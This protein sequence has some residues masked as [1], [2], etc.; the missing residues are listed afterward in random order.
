M[1]KVWIK[2]KLKAHLCLSPLV[3][4][5]LLVEVARPCIVGQDERVVQEKAR[6][7]AVARGCGCT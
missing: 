4:N 6:I 1:V 2:G 3:D 5:V 7:V